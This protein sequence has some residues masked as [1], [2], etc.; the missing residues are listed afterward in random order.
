MVMSKNIPL[1]SSPKLFFGVS[2]LFF[3]WGVATILNDLL[4]PVFKQQFHL[5]YF[6]ALLVQFM[7]FLAYFIMALPM[8]KLVNRWQYKRSTIFG[9]LIIIAGCLVFLLAKQ[10]ATYQLFLL[11]LFVLACGVVMLQVSANTLITLLG[12]RQSAS[13]RLSLAQGIN[14]CGYVLTPLLVGAFISIATLPY[15]YAAM[16][17]FLSLVIG[18]IVRTSFEAY[19]HVPIKVSAKNEGIIKPV[20]SQPYFFLAIIAIFAYVGA[21]VSAGSL[22]ISF[23]GLPAIAHLSINQAS[24]YLALFWGGAMIG[25]FLGSY[26]LCLFKQHQVLL[27]YALINV[28]L[29]LSISFTIGKVA[30]WSLLA[31]GL[32]NS[33]MFPSI[34]ALGLS[35]F[36]SNEVKNS[37]AG[38]LVMANIG[39]ALI[40]ILQGHLADLFGLQHSFLL[41]LFCYG[42]IAC[43]AWLFGKKIL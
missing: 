32:F 11:A 37:A 4:V 3:V 35:L 9:L 14:S 33:I 27:V 38:W 17:V 2:V 31:M 15:I 24:Q 8:V 12:N 22:V 20:F 34:F 5:N 28:L 30:M 10:S 29:V 23:L 39:G 25:R 36:K 43:F 6:S 42:F 7:F 26:I 40:P 1:S 21:E 19:D 41:L 16:I 18:L 13:A